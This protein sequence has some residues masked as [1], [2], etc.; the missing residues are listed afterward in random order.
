MM[1]RGLKANNTTANVLLPFLTSDGGKIDYT[2]YDSM[3]AR[4]RTVLTNDSA[5]ALMQNMGQQQQQQ[6]QQGS[7]QNGFKVGTKRPA[8]ECGNEAKRPS[9]ETGSWEDPKKVVATKQ[10]RNDTKHTLTLAKA[11]GHMKHWGGTLSQVIAR[12]K[13]NKCFKCGE[14]HPVN[15]CPQLN[16]GDKQNVQKHTPRPR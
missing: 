6:Q 3:L 14:D 12:W 4:C 9:T 8:G 10:G 13:Q 11:R 2:S 7:K 5:K 15:S 1:I 16:D